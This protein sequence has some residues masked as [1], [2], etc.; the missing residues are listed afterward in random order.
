MV[1]FQVYLKKTEWSSLAGCNDRVTFFFSIII[2]F[3]MVEVNIGANNWVS[4]SVEAGWVLE[5]HRLLSSSHNVI[6]VGSIR[7]SN[8]K[9]NNRDVCTST[10][11]TN[12]HKNSMHFSCPSSMMACFPSSVCGVFKNQ[13]FGW[14]TCPWLLQITTM[15]AALQSC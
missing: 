7:S 6:F 1:N 9:K 13:L 2:I 4:L 3:G 15:T 5:V 11:P 10:S 8:T 12:R 14:K